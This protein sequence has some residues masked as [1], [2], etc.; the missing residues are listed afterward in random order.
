MIMECPNCH[1]AEDHHVIRGPRNFGVAL[2]N[3]L[4]T[5]VLLRLWPLVSYKRIIAPAR[6]LRRKCLKCGYTFL[7]E[8]P[9]TPDF[10]ECA[11]CGYILKGNISGRCP[12]CG[13]RLPRRYRAYRRIADRALRDK[14]A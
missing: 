1:S 4:N 7:G 8:S 14:R 10:D 13:W 3:A 6:P 12:E 5:L 11:Q 2:L 9:E